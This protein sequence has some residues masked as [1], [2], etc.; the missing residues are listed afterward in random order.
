MKHEPLQRISLPV[1]FY[2]E[3]YW[4]I[5]LHNLFHFPMLR[6]DPH[7]QKEIRLYAELLEWIVK[8]W[9]PY[10]FDASSV[11]RKGA[12]SFSAHEALMIRAALAMPS[13]SGDEKPMWADQLSMREWK[14]FVVKIGRIT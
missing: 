3:I 12:V 10:A 2:T 5:D 13:L 7:V 1:N 6:A 4:K 14:A 9:V 8:G 11:Y